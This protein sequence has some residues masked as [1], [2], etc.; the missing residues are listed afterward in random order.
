MF[1][2]SGGHLVQEM[3]CSMFIL[4]GLNLPIVWKLSNIIDP[5]LQACDMKACLYSWKKDSYINPLNAALLVPG[6][7]RVQGGSALYSVP[8]P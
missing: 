4:S 1:S 3:T 6:P 8:L 5:V 7:A 2:W